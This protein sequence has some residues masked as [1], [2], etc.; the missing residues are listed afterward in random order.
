MQTA[1]GEPY[2]RISMR[3]VQVCISERIIEDGNQNYS[4]L[5]LLGKIL[6]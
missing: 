3:L 4:D 2:S 1:K 5:S 6:A